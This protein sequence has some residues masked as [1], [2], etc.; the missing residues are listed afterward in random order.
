[1]P[2]SCK[3]H[4]NRRLI[5]TSCIRSHPSSS[6]SSSR[7]KRKKRIFPSFSRLALVCRW[8][9]DRSVSIPAANGKREA[10]RE[11]EEKMRY[12]SRVKKNCFSSSSF[13]RINISR[14]RTNLNTL[15]RYPSVYVWPVCRICKRLITYVSNLSGLVSSCYCCLIINEINIL[16]QKHRYP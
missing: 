3:Q 15:I 13:F 5:S 10:E 8:L 7:K 4:A 12:F 16:F 1:M 11:R 9:M 14:G 6:S 2:A